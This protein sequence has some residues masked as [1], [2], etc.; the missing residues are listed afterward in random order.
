MNSKNCTN[1]IGENTSVSMLLRVVLLIYFASSELGVK[2]ASGMAACGVCT[3]NR[4]LHGACSYAGTHC[5]Y[6]SFGA[7]QYTTC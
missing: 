7:V 3:Q 5:L 6:D 2:H 4:L 1:C